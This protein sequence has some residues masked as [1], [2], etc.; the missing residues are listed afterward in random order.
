MTSNSIKRILSDINKLK[1]NPLDHEGI[2]WHLNEDNIYNFKALIIGPRGTPYQ[3]GFYFFDFM[4][5]ECYPLEPPKVKY[6]TQYNNIRF[7]P[8]LYT[9]GTV[10]LSILNTWSGPSWTP[11]NTL[12]SILMSLLGLVFVEHPLINEP[13]HEN[14]SLNNLYQYD[15][16]IEHE[17]IRGAILQMLYNVTINFEMF[18]DRVRQ[19][20]INN[21]GEYIDRVKSLEKMKDKQIFECSTYNI[22]IHSNYS[23]IIKKM[24]EVYHKLT[25]INIIL[26]E[27]V[28]ITVKELRDLAEKYLVST[29]KV[30]DNKKVYKL[31]NELYNDVQLAIFKNT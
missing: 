19:Y 2:F 22:S 13:G 29:K 8:N 11:C 4:I 9:N 17:S 21:F 15:S 18:E 24:H 25:G 10:C 30:I 3:G 12:T 23:N 31:K 5:P 16:I 27:S 1:E 7:N 6:C 26:P 14:S 28:N 20:F